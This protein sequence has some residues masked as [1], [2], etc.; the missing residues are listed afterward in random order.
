[1]SSRSSLA[2]SLEEATASAATMSADCDTPRAHSA[3]HVLNSATETSTTSAASK[4]RVRR[5]DALWQSDNVYQPLLKRIASYEEKLGRKLQQVTE[6]CRTLVSHVES[7]MADLEGQQPKVNR[8]L[9]ELAGN[10][11]G[12]SDEL[13]ALLRHGDHIDSKMAEWRRQ[14]EEDFRAQLSCIEQRHLKDATHG[15]IS[16]GSL[17]EAQRR[18]EQRMQKLEAFVKERVQF[19]A[20]AKKGLGNFN[21]RAVPQGEHPDFSRAQTEDSQQC[22]SPSRSSPQ[23]MEKLER[24]IQDSHDVHSKLEAQDER[25]KT[26]RTRSDKQEQQLRQITEEVPVDVAGRLQELRRLVQEH[27]TTEIAHYEKIEVLSKRLEQQEQYHEELRGDVLCHISRG[28]PPRT[29]VGTEEPESNE[30]AEHAN[31]AARRLEERIA[32]IEED[33]QDLRLAPSGPEALQD[34]IANLVEQIKGEVLPRLIDQGDQLEKLWKK[35]DELEQV[36]NKGLN[37]T[38]ELENQVKPLYPLKDANLLDLAPRIGGICDNLQEVLPRVM[39]GESRLVDLDQKMEDQVQ[40]FVDISG[41]L[42]RIEKCFEAESADRE[43]GF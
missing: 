28:E 12:L 20:E 31:C 37:Q 8:R 14:I 11:T 22:S 1:M 6:D 7:R 3:C 36:V 25:L 33:M 43:V 29:S 40:A 18:Q 41:R 42:S 17:E 30:Q 38:V 23:V 5:K 26:L 4:Q 13:Q 15:R 9:A 2:V 16:T 21:A 27:V 19:A 39:E 10:C 35:D 34:K 32:A 24:L